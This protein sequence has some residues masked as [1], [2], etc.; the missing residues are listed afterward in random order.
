MAIRCVASQKTK[1][2]QWKRHNISYL[3]A[4]RWLHVHSEACLTS[5]GT[6]AALCGKSAATKIFGRQ[7][8]LAN[9]FHYLGML[10]SLEKSE[11]L[12]SVF[13]EHCCCCLFSGEFCEIEVPSVF[14]HVWPG[15]C[16]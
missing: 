2:I 7:T 11:V 8:R 5:I 13:S 12:T 3:F 15:V 1:T 10:G 6:T 9:S 16:G 14:P 4:G